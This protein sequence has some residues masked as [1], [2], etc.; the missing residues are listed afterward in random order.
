MWHVSVNFGTGGDNA[1]R[2]GDHALGNVLEDI[3]CDLGLNATR[4]A[5]CLRSSSTI[6]G[7]DAVHLAESSHL[8]PSGAHRLTSILGARGRRLIVGE[9]L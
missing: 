8:R 1:I 3:E 5:D 6:P 9:N 2:V 4:R 7:Q